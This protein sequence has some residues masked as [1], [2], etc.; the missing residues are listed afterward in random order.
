MSNSL[1]L[2]G[3]ALAYPKMVAV[4]RSAGLERMY[5]YEWTWDE[6]AALIKAAES[7]GYLPAVTLGWK[8]Y[9]RGYFLADK[10]ST[11]ALR[12]DQLSERTERLKHDESD[13]TRGRWDL[14]KDKLGDLI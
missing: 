8:K 6:W 3:D 7:E 11:E 13:P 9:L 10:K 2:M 12:R 5:A 4:M 1:Q 14:A